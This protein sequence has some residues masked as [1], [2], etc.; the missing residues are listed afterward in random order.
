MDGGT[1]LALDHG[2]MGHKLRHLQGI[3]EI[4]QI[5]AL[6]YPGQYLGLARRPVESAVYLHRPKIFGIVGQPITFLRCQRHRV[7]SAHPIVIGPAATA[8]E[9]AIDSDTTLDP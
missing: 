7:E 6:F 4:R 1:G 3:L 8:Y 9:I 2:F 5:I